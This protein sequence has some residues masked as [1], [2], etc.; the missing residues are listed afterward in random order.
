MGAHPYWYLV[1]YRKDLQRALDELRERE[2]QAGRYNPVIS[3]LKFSEP[4]FSKQTPGPDH[5]TIE[6]AIMD[7]A[8]DGTRSI[9]DIATVG[10]T[11]DYG[12]AAPISAKVLKQLYG[13]DQPTREMLKE[14]KEFL[15]DI[16]RGQCVYCIVYTTSGAPNE[17]FFAGY[18]FD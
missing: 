3:F 15:N 13:T 6:D 10:T 5:A 16:E 8:E 14:N 2:F 11:P 17:I 12:V 4:A 9:L 1:P 7:A 18:S